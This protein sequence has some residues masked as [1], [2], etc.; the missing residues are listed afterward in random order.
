[1]IIYNVTVNIEASA[2]DEWLKF[3]QE[4]H[5]SDVMDTGCFTEFTFSK[6]LT[7]Q[8][9]EEGMTYSIQYKCNDMSDYDNYQTAHAPPIQ[10]DLSDKF[11]DKFV[12]F[13]TLLEVIE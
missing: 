3:M 6:I 11:G 5:I 10:K 4:I 8:E 9:D 13:R 12:A 2:N 1:M 7:T